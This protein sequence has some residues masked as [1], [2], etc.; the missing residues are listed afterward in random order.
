MCVRETTNL[1]SQAREMQV[2]GT[3]YSGNGTSSPVVIRSQADIAAAMLT[4]VASLQAAQQEIYLK[5]G[6]CES[7]NMRRF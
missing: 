1:A 6:E 2:S 5:I 7:N 3:T 4:G